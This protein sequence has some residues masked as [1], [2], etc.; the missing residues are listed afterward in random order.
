MEAKPEA[1]SR[2]N[3]LRSD[4][5]AAVVSSYEQLDPDFIAELDTLSMTIDEYE[6]MLADNEPLVITTD[7]TVG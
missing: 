6:R 1:M 4:N 5:L 2:V 7:N 3:D